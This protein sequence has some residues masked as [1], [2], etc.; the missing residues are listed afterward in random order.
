MSDNKSQKDQRD[1]SQVSGSEDYEIQYF[2]NKMN[3]SAEEVR[4][5]IRETGSNDRKKLE[6]YL[7]DKHKK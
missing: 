4:Q 6:E 2:K 3:V 7:N 5:A 1:R